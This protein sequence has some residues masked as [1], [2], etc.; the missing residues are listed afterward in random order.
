MGDKLSILSI[1]I[2]LLGAGVALFFKSQADKA[3]AGAIESKVQVKDAPLAARQQ[4][5]ETKIHEIDAGIQKMKDDQ[6]KM[7]Q[8]R[9]TDQQRAD[10]WNKK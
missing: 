8:Q 10:N 3:G 1:I 5:D 6:E 4:D 7:K 2:G 9:L